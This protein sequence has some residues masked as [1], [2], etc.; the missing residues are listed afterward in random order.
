MNDYYND[1]PDHPEPP[2]WYSTLEDILNDMDPPPSVANAIRKAMDDWVDDPN[3]QQ[4]FESIDD[5]LD[6]PLGEACR[7]D[8]PECESCQ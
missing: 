5:D 3:R 4:Y 2:E 8:N 6:E 7:L 1:P